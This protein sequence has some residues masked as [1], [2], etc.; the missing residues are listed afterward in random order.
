[1]SPFFLL[2]GPIPRPSLTIF[3]ALQTLDILTTLI[4]LQ[5]GAR[6]SSVFIGQLMQVGPVAALLISKIFAVLLAAAAM[7]FKRPRVV[8]VLNLWFVVIVA[9]NL[10]VIVLS[11]L[12]VR[13]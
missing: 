11:G 8:V 9:W 7:K 4:G 5:V 2:R 1:V 12:G 10:A 13:L 6:E 3:V